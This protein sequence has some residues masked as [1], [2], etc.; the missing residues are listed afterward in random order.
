ME[1]FLI[2]LM[3]VGGELIVCDHGH[4]KY[5][6]SG[7]HAVSRT[8]KLFGVFNVLNFLPSWSGDGVE[9]ARQT[10]KSRVMIEIQNSLY[11]LYLAVVCLKVIYPTIPTYY[12]YCMTLNGN[13]FN[14]NWYETRSA[15]DWWHARSVAL[16]GRNKLKIPG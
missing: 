2:F 14:E 13:K 6:F 1:I 9:L 11:F 12:T 5:A 10:L 3:R 8:A 7:V 4:N 16:T 15:R